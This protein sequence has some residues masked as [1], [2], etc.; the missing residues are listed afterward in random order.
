MMTRVRATTD[1]PPMQDWSAERLQAAQFAV[2]L[3]RGEFVKRG[4]NDAL[5]ETA[6]VIFRFLT[7]AV[8]AYFEFGTVLEQATKY[9]TDDQFGG[10]MSQLKDTQQVD[11]TVK[12]RDAK[13][14]EVG[15]DPTTTA[16]D[17]QWSSADTT[18]ATVNVGADNR[19]ATVVA[20]NVGSTVVTAT[21][22]PIV[23]TQAVDVI[24]GDAVAMEISVGTPTDQAP[25]APAGP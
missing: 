11:I 14:F 23:V 5:I 7:G 24:A 4:D 16:D 8:M 12:A 17:I 20:G 3:Y 21:L 13:G 19:T 25:A 22:G 1:P 2:E 18:I 15:D 6:G 10:S 9:P